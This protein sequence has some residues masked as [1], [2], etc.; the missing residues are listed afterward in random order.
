M[1]KTY[2]LGRSKKVNFIYLVALIVVASLIIVKLIEIYLENDIITIKTDFYNQVNRHI[3]TKMVG[4]MNPQIN[5]YVESKEEQLMQQQF[6]S[7]LNTLYG[8][9]V[10]LVPFI[11]NV[12]NEDYETMVENYSYVIKEKDTFENVIDPYK[13]DEVFD[14]LSIIEQSKTVPYDETLLK[15]LNDFNFLMTKM[16][17]VDRT[18]KVTESDFPIEEFLS[19]DARVDLTKP[20]PKI[21]IFHT[22]A[23]EDFIDSRIGLKEDTVVGVGDVLTSL[24]QDKYNIQVI[25]HREQYDIID[26]VLD[27]SNAYNLIEKPVVNILKENPSIEVCIDIHRD[28][29]PDEIRLISSINGKQTA[30][31]MFFNGICKMIQ[32]GKSVSLQKSRPNPYIKENMAFSLQMHL[33]ANE[34]YSNFTRRIYIKG[35]RYNMHIAPKTL[36]IEVGAQNNTVQEAKNAMEPLAEI[37]YQVISGQ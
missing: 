16:Y 1:E 20:G 2:L 34:L 23:A 7:G 3:Y 19:M 32:G 5:F 21:L 35:Y 33:K 27:R 25:H 9:S 37:L 13:E 26:G 17:T 31:I 4:F 11:L 22:H 15:K 36:L 6:D 29:I 30:K 8:L 28:G 18:V 24:L 10:P 12:K 14:T